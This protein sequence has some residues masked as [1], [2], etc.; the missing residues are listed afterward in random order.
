MRPCPCF[1]NQ[2]NFMENLFADGDVD[3]GKLSQLHGPRHEA[4][5]FVLTFLLNRR[6]LPINNHGNQGI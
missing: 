5:Q 3:R 4:I 2:L 1:T 6:V